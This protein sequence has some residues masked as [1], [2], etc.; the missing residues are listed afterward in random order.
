MNEIAEV[1]TKYLS[2]TVEVLAALVIGLLLLSFCTDMQSIF[3]ILT[4]ALP[5]KQS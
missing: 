4:M 1:V 5:I 3:Y 2:S